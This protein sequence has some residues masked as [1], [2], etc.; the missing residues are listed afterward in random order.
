[1]GD[2]L[3]SAHS[4]R[5]KDTAPTGSPAPLRG[6]LAH[7]LLWILI[8]GMVVRAGL[9]FWFRNEPLSIWD[10]R[11][12]NQLAVNL[13]EKGELSLEGHLCSI[14]PPLYPAVVAGV[15]ACC[16]LENYQAVRVLQAILALATVALLYLLGSEIYD[17]RIGAWAAGF[18]CFYPSM[19]GQASL[20][21]SETLFTFWLTLGCLAVVRF[22]HRQA[23]G[24]LVLGG[25]VIGL[26]ALTRSVLWLSPPLLAVYVVLVAKTGFKRRLAGA[27]L[28]LVA[29]AATIAPWSIRNTRLQKTL[30]IIDVMGGRNFMMGNYDYTPMLRAWDAISMEGDK[31]W[32][33]VLAAHDPQSPFVSQGE[34]DKRALRYG[35]NFVRNN[36]GLTIRRDVAKLFNFW[37]LER[38][39]VA[40]M[41]RGY[42]G[43]PPLAVILPLTAVIFGSYAAAMIAGIFGAVMTPPED[44]R[45]H[46][47]LLL[48]IAFICGLHTLVFA[49]S[50]YHLP[51]M[52]LVLTYS[53]A[54]LLG[55]RG[56]WRRRGTRSFWIAAGM[57]AI[58]VCAWLWEIVIVDF[59]RFMSILKD[60]T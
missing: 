48:V 25:V 31:A 16:G 20:L 11:D 23:I 43:G 52:P 53:A 10:E 17:R 24:Y 47:F 35:L 58:L 36:P 8:A 46:V 33:A 42:F 38:S 26:G 6:R 19:L 28:M 3:N 12:Y 49:H 27:G 40:G 51:L 30:V 21:L 55:V 60:S 34:L 5:Q 59:E 44:W 57:T 9:L 29:F 2:S 50:R 7:P 56:I 22:F 15:Y 4:G 45:V 32:Y 41:R 37:Q 54:G 18:Y 13:V 39:L 1:M 14:R